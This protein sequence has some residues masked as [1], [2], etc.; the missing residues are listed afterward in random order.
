MKAVALLTLLL[1]LHGCTVVLWRGPHG[2]TWVHADHIAAAVVA[3]DRLLGVEIVDAQGS[4]RQYVA[5]LDGLRPLDLRGWD[6]GLRPQGLPLADPAKVSQA[7]EARGAC[8]WPVGVAAVAMSPAALA[9]LAAEPPS[10]LPADASPWHVAVAVHEQ[11]EDCLWVFDARAPGR[12][13]LVPLPLPTYGPDAGIGERICLTP[14]AV[15]VDVVC[16]P[17]YAV[18]GLLLLAGVRIGH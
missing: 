1:S 2:E 11:F 10:P 18:I 9:A 3:D 14:F 7:R 8:E 4:H 5:N 16:L 15:A 13:I 17:L 12:A 6:L